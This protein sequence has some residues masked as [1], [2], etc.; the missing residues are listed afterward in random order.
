[1]RHCQKQKVTE[2]RILQ[3]KSLPTCILRVTSL[4]GQGRFTALS[5]VFGKSHHKYYYA[6]YAIYVSYSA[7]IPHIVCNPLRPDPSNSPR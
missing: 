5:Q 3:K 2:S 6:R 4:S 7:L 1:M